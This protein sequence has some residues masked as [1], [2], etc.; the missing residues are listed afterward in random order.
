MFDFGGR[1]RKLSKASRDITSLGNVLLDL[2][3]CKKDELASA[4]EEQSE[5]LPRLGELLITRGII[6]RDQ[7]SHA[8]LRQEVLRGKNDP[9]LLNQYGPCQ[10]RQAIAEAAKRLE[11]IA[12][13]AQILAE[14]HSR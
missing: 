11:R 4:I 5:S 13:S 1:R 12:T 8:L 14:K 9:S 7:L 3:Y 6:T 2:G 10:R